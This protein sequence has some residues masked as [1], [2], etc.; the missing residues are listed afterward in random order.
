MSKGSRPRPYNPDKFSDGWDAIFGKKEDKLY[1][2]ID[3]NPE[4]PTSFVEESIEAMIEIE[5]GNK[6]EYS[7]RKK[8]H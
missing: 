4:L 6:S 5:N 8:I 2:A 7:Y 1:Q 3:D